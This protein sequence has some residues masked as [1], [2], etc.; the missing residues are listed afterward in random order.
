MTGAVVVFAFYIVGGRVT[1]AYVNVQTWCGG[2]I[3]IL[4]TD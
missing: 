2:R 1:V 3:T 4:R